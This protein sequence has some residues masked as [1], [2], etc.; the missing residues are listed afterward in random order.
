MPRPCINCGALIASGSR[1]TTCKPAR[2][3]NGW[4]WTAR[5]NEILERD[6]H[7]CTASGCTATEQLTVEHITAIHL[8]GTD[9]PSN[10]T[11]RCPRHRLDINQH[12]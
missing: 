3:R 5:R 12:A 9:N 11:T 4:A 1:C 6:H 8:D 10:L 2:Q 7:A